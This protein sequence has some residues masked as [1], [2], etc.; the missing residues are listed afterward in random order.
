MLE[1]L[2]IPEPGFAW[3]RLER[4]PLNGELILAPLEP[5]RLSLPARVIA[6]LAPAL[7]EA[8]E[9]LAWEP[10]TYMFLSVTPTRA[11]SGAKVWTYTWVGDRPSATMPGRPPN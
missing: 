8:A 3:A 1:D 6:V 9:T 2:P 4:G 10:T 5:E 7:D 11:R